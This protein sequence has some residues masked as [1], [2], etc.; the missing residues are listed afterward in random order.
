MMEDTIKQQIESIVNSPTLYSELERKNEEQRRLDLMVWYEKYNE[1]NEVYNFYGMDCVDSGSLDEWLDR[2][3]FRKQRHDINASFYPRG[4]KFPIDYTVIMRD[5]RMFEGFCE[6]VLG[7]GNQY[8]P[9]I[10]FIIGSNMLQKTKWGGVKSVDF[11]EFVKRYLNCKL[12]FKES[13]GCSG[14]SVLVVH[15]KENTIICQNKEYSFDDF[16]VYITSTHATTWIVQEFIIQHSIMNKMNESSVNTMRIVTFNTGEEIFVAPVNMRFGYPDAVVD[17]S[18]RCVRLDA[19]GV[20]D[21]YAYDFVNKK[22]FEC[23][24]KG[25]RIPYYCEAIEFAK[26]MHTYIPEIFT[27]GWDI[28]ITPSGPHLIEGNDGWEPWL[29]QFP[30]GNKM[31]KMWDELV[32]K[33]KEYYK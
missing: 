13:F 15:I 10:A 29:T 3:L 28:C 24:G 2:G 23:H 20:V 30:L 8:S 6:S 11:K 21:D 19:E 7:Y 18:S 25:L 33:R 9:S 14:E 26:R 12:V 16:F 22:R 31:R 32:I 5:K 1:V 17:N 4:S 27:V